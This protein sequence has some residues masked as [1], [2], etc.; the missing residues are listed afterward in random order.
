[1]W[2]GRWLPFF[3]SQIFFALLCNRVESYLQFVEIKGFNKASG[4]F[5]LFDFFHRLLVGITCHKDNR[6]TEGGTY[7]FGNLDSVYVTA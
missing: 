6:N 4:R 2:M 3:R 7:L 1:M 5:Y